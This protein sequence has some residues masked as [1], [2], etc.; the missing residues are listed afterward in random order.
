MR[1]HHTFLILRNWNHS[2]FNENQVYISDETRHLPAA[3][4]GSLLA[5]SLSFRFDFSHSYFISSVCVDGKW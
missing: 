3:A 1:D 4:A 2:I 5:V